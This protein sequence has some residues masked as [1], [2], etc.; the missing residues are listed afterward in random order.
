MPNTDIGPFYCTL[1][2]VDDSTSVEELIRLY[3]EYPFV[4][5]GV[6]YS[7]TQQG[8]GRYAS[9]R[10]KLVFDPAAKP[11]CALRRKVALREARA[12]GV[13]HAVQG[14]WKMGQGPG[15]RS[16]SEAGDWRLEGLLGLGDT[17]CEDGHHRRGDEAHRPTAKCTC[18]FV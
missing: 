14:A 12:P 11:P 1:T 15:L 8:Q 5:W 10:W 16:S 4:E 18:D 9:M 7:A 2:G 17:R 6:L 13:R 3:R